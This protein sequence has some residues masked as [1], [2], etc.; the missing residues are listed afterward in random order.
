VAHRRDPLILKKGHEQALGISIYPGCE[1]MQYSEIGPDLS[2]EAEVQ[3]PPPSP[4]MA[5]AST[6][7]LLGPYYPP[8]LCL[9]GH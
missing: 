2:P 3:P 7:G 6:E 1:W 5:H 8:Q 9:T 4:E